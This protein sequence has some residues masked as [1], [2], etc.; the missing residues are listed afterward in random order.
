MRE[1]VAL[2]RQKVAPFTKYA[3]AELSRRARK[4]WGR[5]GPR[6]RK[7]SPKG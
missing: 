7:R 4:P 5:A 6:S 2:N 3:M 1:D